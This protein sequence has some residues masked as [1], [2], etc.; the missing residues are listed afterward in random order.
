MEAEEPTKGHG[1]A[2]GAA[3]TTTAAA[4]A[5]AAGGSGAGTIAALSYESFTEVLGRAADLMSPPPPEELAEVRGG[6]MVTF[7]CVFKDI[8]SYLQEIA[9]LYLPERK[10]LASI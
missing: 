4:H 3:T 9:E 1:A 8:S 7:A 2:P 5:A 10:E 6:V